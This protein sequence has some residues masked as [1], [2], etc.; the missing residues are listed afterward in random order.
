MQSI[1]V[2]SLNLA[3]NKYENNVY[4]KI[5][6]FIVG[7][8]ATADKL[9]Y[10]RKYLHKFLIKFETVLTGYSLAQGKPIHEKNFKLKILC[11]TPFIHSL[12]CV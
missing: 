1:R 9:L 11:Q 8:A 4:L 7:A 3:L 6:S 10:I 12:S 5:F 2:N